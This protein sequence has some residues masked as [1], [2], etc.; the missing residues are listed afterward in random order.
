MKKK[1]QPSRS[2]K[3]KP[4]AQEVNKQSAQIPFSKNFRMQAFVLF[5]F[6]FLLYA[7]TLVNKYA[8][9]DGLMISENKFTK[10][11]I[12]GIKDIL[13]NDAMV[14]F[15][16]EQNLLQGGRYRPLS[17]ICFAIEYQIFGL[18]PFI[19][20]LINVLLYGLLCVLLFHLLRKLFIKFKSDTWYFSLPFLITAL[21][22]AHPLHTEAIANIKGR[23][24]I[25]SLLGSLG[26]L[27]FVL[28]YL[29]SKKIINLLWALL[30]FFLALLSK[31]NAITFLA[32]VPLV[33]YVFTESKWKDYAVVTGTLLGG[34]VVYACLRYAALGFFMS[35][36]VDKELFNNPFAEASLAQKF[37][38]IVYTWIL[39]L[40]LLIFPHPLTHDYY[41]YQIPLV[42]WGDYRTILSLLVYG[43]LAIFALIKIRKKNLIAFSI[44]FFAITFSIQSNLLFNIGTFMNE[45]FM[46]VSLIGFCIVV[47]LF[48]RW[49]AKRGT[50]EQKMF[51]Q[52]AT[53][54]IILILLG[55]SV[56]TI[57]RN[58]DWKDGETLQFADVKTSVNSA[59]C[60][61]LCGFIM[62]ERARQNP[63]S[64]AR[65]DLYKQ[66]EAYLAQGLKIY[67]KNSSALN[68]MGEVSLALGK[69]DQ[70]IDAYMKNLKYNPEDAISFS[71]LRV[72]V[73]VYTKNKKYEEALKLLR[74]LT[75]MQAG[76]Y[77]DYNTMGELYGKFLNKMDSSV[78]YFEKAVQINPKYTP[79]LE[80]LG[81]VHGIQGDYQKSIQY[82]LQALPLDSMNTELLGN[83]SR[84]YQLMGNTAKA[85]EMMIKAMKYRK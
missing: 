18:N 64:L 74:K 56:K 3:H 1:P 78:F 66:S 67:D 45:R 58:M 35:S 26:V 57:S 60:N 51:P 42:S 49:I 25:M 50:G 21:F 44:L 34:I 37:A 4:A 16:G 10:K 5:L 8:L 52:I 55:Y 82:F 40:K 63:D 2:P 24:E 43:A 69:Y 83:I 71:N 77:T 53:V 33:M 85:N 72:I 68:N 22:A 48:I 31:E 61:Y 20:H 41:P 75:V 27:W 12:S 54:L 65:I 9:D 46:F 76:N 39:Y 32:V 38:T 84:T 73:H 13:F 17:Q 7:N 28:K 36:Y 30:I 6:A 81:I 47:S 23:D 80:N 19:G 70:S 29:E 62:L 11:G 59:R 14:G 15:F 79:A